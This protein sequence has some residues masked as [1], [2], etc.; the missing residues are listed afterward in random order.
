MTIKDRQQFRARVI[1]CSCVAL[2]TGLT[3]FNFD[4]TQ[5]TIQ[6]HLRLV[7]AF[8]FVFRSFQTCVF[9][10]NFSQNRQSVIFSSIL[11]NGMNMLMNTVVLFPME[12]AVITREFQNGTYRML[13]YYLSRIITA[14]VFQ[15]LYVFAYIT[16]LYFLANMVPYALEYLTYVFTVSLVGMIAVTLGLIIGAM[17]PSIDLG[18]SLVTPLLMPLIVFSGYLISHSA[19]KPWFLW[20][21]YLSFFQYAFHIL[22]VSQFN[23]LSFDC[24]CTNTTSIPCFCGGQSAGVACPPYCSC[25]P[26]VNGTSPLTPDA[27]RQDTCPLYNGCANGT[28]YLQIN[29]IGDNNV[30]KRNMIILS[31]F[32]MVLAISGYYVMLWRGRKKTA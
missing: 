9:S 23:H 21:Y 7:F 26:Y 14:I 29:E 30:L 27:S 20:I 19:I 1:L 18:P 22:L 5:E 25:E 24:C 17:V 4:N 6:V 13:A 28:L 11:F 15:F 16:I 2:F 3:Y 31:V 32:W 10:C 12:R 8:S